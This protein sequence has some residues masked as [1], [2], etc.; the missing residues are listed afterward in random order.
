M[1]LSA[2]K[3]R[4]QK[5]NWYLSSNQLMKLGESRYSIN[6]LVANNNILKIS[7]SLYRWKNADLDG[8][9]DFLDISKIEPQGV[10]C[11]Y[12]AMQYYHLSTFISDKYY[13]AIPRTNWKRKG[14]EQY[15][16]VIK[17]WKNR[18]FDLG[19]EHI[20]L[21]RYS[22][23]MYNLEK[24]VCDC[25]RYRNELGLNTLKEVITA[26]FQSKKKNTRKLM[27]YAN[28]LGV[29]KILKEYTGLIL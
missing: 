26:Y 2:L 28:E 7:S 6:R 11:L 8:N 19:I 27:Q 18:S 1:D 13:F 14:L 17:T 24:T 29:G 21:G 5:N 16:I 15:P 4:F 3:K 23:R 10:F 22:I 25:I 9:D 12:T 20:K